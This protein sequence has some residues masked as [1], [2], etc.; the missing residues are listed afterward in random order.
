[1]GLEPVDMGYPLAVALMALA[2]FA[3]L[4]A[5]ARVFRLTLRFMAARSN[6]FLPMGLSKVVAVIAVVALFWLV[7]DGVLVRGAL[8]VAD[9]LYQQLDRLIEPQTRPPA[10]PLKTGSGAS[11]LA[12]HELGR[13]GREFIS[14][15]PT[16]EDIS[17]FSGKAALE[18]VRV[19]VG[20]RS[21]DTVE[22]RA[23]LAL[24]ELKRAGGFERPVLVVI[25]PTGTGWVD[26]A[27]LNSL[28]YL[29][30][31]NVASVALQYSYLGSW[32]Y[33]IM[34]ADYGEIGRASCR[35]SVARSG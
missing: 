32:L 27:A 16:R 29:H 31:G 11:L 12:W 17:A 25:T 5:L 24:E 21:A 1:M 26:P 35:E 19:Y 9:A 18:P 20:L 33:L 15:G 2:V 34:G 3:I 30:D 13:A 7:I 23:R 14:S 22:A 10:D 6:R 8:R 4:A 28:E